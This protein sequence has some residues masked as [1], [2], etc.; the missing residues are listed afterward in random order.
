VFISTGDDENAMNPH[1]LRLLGAWLFCIAVAIGSGQTVN[2][3]TSKQILGPVP[4]A[5]QPLNSLPMAMAWSPD[6]RYLAI[7]NAGFGTVESNY[8][9][10]IAILDTATG[11]VTDYPE[12]RTDILAPQTYYSGIAFS[13][14]GSHIYVSFDSISAPEGGK[15]DQTGNAV[16]VYR[17]TP[18]NGGAADTLAPERLIPVPMWALPAGKTQHHGEMPLPE[19]RAIPAPAGITVVKG[20]DGA[21][22]LLVA[23][24]YSDDVLL[25][26]A[27]SGKLETRFDLSAGPTIPTNYPVAVIASRDGR[28]AWV[29]LW[30]GSAVAEI[31]LKSG[32][33]MQKLPLLPPV[34]PTAPSSHPIAMALSPDETTLYVALANRDGVA[35]IHVSGPKM[36]TAAFY[37][38]RLPGQAF[39]GSMPDAVAVTDDGKTLLAAN[40]GSNAVAV[41]DLTRAPRAKAPVIPIGFVPTEWYPTALAVEGNHL[42]VATGKGEGTKANVDPQP[43]APNPP[44]TQ[45]KRL[46]RPHTYIATMLHGSLATIALDDARAHLREMTRQVLE[47]NLMY[48]AQGRIEF[49]G[50]GNPIRHVIYIIRE[51]RTYD[52]IL[53]DLGV[54]DG[55][56]SLTMYGEE[57]TPNLHALAKQFGVLDNFY[58]SGEVSG[59]G[60]VWSTAGIDSDYNER[61]WQIAYRGHERPYDFEGVTEAGYPI[62]ENI[63]DVDEPG[64]GYLW[65]DLTRSHKSLYHFG[66]FISTKFCDDSGEAPHSRPLPQQGGTPEGTHLC[67]HAA[68]RAGDPI[69]ENYGGGTS[70]YPWPIPLIYQNVATKPEL[71]GHFDPQYPDFNISFPDQLRV[72]EFLVHFSQWVEDLKAGHDTMPQFVMLRLPNDHTGGTRPGGPT[73]KASVADNDLA[74]GR[75][76]DAVSHS[77]YWNSTAFFV[78]E[79]DAQ[80]GADH[81]DAHR[82]IMLAISKYAPRKD[83]P[84]VDHNFYTTVSTVHTILTLLGCPPMN[85]NDAFAPLMA[86]EFTGAGDQP[87]FDADYRNRDNG[88][89][90]TANVPKAEGAKESSRM[91]FSHEDRA[92]PVKLN[93]ILW[94]DAMGNK[95]VPWMLTHPHGV[96]RD[97]DD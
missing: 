38:T 35:A 1:K 78:L 41:F 58:D 86:P 17:F 31:D 84:F 62:E 33:V 12:P 26:D 40:S 77:P 60:H 93:V 56:S 49:Q 37:D 47:S 70:Q 61:T 21:E 66:E 27:A 28:R 8:E 57:I 55:D 7:V 59:D 4:G 88:L 13:A 23:D 22:K 53:G 45:T 52:Q 85:N 89:I 65:T 72:S 95:P 64:S 16:G 80:D 3:P 46:D 82:S 79:D 94:K 36:R 34:R 9:Q 10:S 67:E 15:E 73:P 18:G 75:A 68:I 25:L 44:P 96:K 83:A 51:N 24:E 54:G 69:P 19:D 5:P 48:A 50:G 92:D 20:A 90:Y 32:Q 29:A 74:V 42:Y 30:N 14:D 63:P 76:V 81:V 91:D 39:F 87:A 71:V 97:G 11:K 6:H 43:K 2:L